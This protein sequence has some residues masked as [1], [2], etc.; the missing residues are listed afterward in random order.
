[1]NAPLALRPDQLQD[2]TT[3]LFHKRRHIHGGEPGTGKTPTICVLQAGRWRQHG[4]GTVWM[5]PKA[6]LEKNLEEAMLW[7]AWEPGEVVIVDGTKRQVDKQLASGARVFL[8]GF[9]RFER[10]WQQLPD[11][12]KAVDV[13]EWHKGFG[14]HESKRTQ[15]L[16]EFMDTRGEW[17]CPMTGTIYKGK[18]DTI[19]PA[20]KIIEPRYYG[21]YK[22]FQNVHHVLDP[23]S[24]KV[25][26]YTGLEALGQVLATHSIKRLWSEIHGP[27]DKVVQIERAKMSA[28]QLAAYKT[29]EETA[30]LE[31]EQFFIDGT[32]PGVSFIRARQ[33]MEHPNRFPDLRDPDGRLKL[34][35]VD[36]TPGE[37][38]GK[39]ELFDLDVTN[40][41]ENGTPLVTYAALVPQ[42]E[43]L[44]EYA[45]RLGLRCALLNGETPQAER[46]RIDKAFQ[47]GELQGL[48]C[49]PQV[50]D[51]G[52]NWQTCGEQEVNDCV[53][54]S[55]DYNDVT[56]TQAYKRFMRRRRQAA[57]R[58][59]IYAYD[60]SLDWHIM[61][62]TKKKSVEGAQ[63][64]QGREPLPFL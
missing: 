46:G 26:G 40:A 3:L 61:R 24:G 47:A 23:F 1:M 25:I 21:T 63:V 62:L 64:E 12:V 60:D 38:P 4:H 10:C 54:A 7:G 51:C 11:Y 9:T 33:L 50:A 34:P 35:P 57:L 31:L 32:K 43:Q 55:M 18:P 56:F 22:A 15:A 45:Q 20:L 59:K 29:F 2:L 16:Y 48:I 14:G 36:V 13:D 37:L 44:L 42:Q 53:F 49:S 27:E 28:A 39:L 30:I 52:F 41:L 6:L 58:I 8:M 19:Y 5:M 17:F